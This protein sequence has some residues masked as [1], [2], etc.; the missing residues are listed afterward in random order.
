MLKRSAVLKEILSGEVTENVVEKIHALLGTIGE[1]VRGGAVPLD[2][3]IIFKVSCHRRHHGRFRDEP[4]LTHASDWA[5]TRKTIPTR[6]RSRMSRS[7][8]A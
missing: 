2:D 8:C 6:N 4:Q 1:N 5:R 3:F 7:R